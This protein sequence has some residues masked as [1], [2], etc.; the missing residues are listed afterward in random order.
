MDKYINIEEVESYSSDFDSESD[1]DFKIISNEDNIFD[2]F[3]FTVFNS[4]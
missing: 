2:T 4:Y 3:V 1:E